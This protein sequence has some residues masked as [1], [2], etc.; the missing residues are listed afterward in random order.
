MNNI[1]DLHRITEKHEKLLNDMGEK[2]YTNDRI[3][4]RINDYFELNL[5]NISVRTILDSI[6]DLEK[7]IDSK[8]STLDVKK[9]QS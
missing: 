3:L 2:V 9:V 8:A 4:S 1:R 7:L 5:K 6:K